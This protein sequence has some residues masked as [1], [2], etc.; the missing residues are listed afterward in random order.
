MK[1]NARRYA[2]NGR[3]IPILFIALLAGCSQSPFER[4]PLPELVN[5]DPTT[6][7]TTFAAATPSRFVSDDTVIIHAP[8]QDLAILGELRV[9]RK[10]GMFQLMALNQLGVQLFFLEG[11]SQHTDIKFAVP[12][13]MEKKDLLMSIAADLRRMYF[14]L[15]PDTDADVDIHSKYVDFSKKGPD[16][17]MVYE[18]GGAPTILLE[19]RLDGFW[20]TLWKVS[21]YQYDPNIAG[22]FPRGIV[23]DNDHFHYQII[24]KNR[25]WTA[26]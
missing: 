25:S 2:L 11:D 23:M 16:G 15:S 21:Y 13:L 5:P 22:L 8:F 24:V 17:K 3:L 26:E 18:F 14:D 10:T 9:N 4:P 12:P 1:T 19:K 20:G 7:R 6:I